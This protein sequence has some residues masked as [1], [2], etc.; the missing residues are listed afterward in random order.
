MISFAYLFFAYPV[1]VILF[2][3]SALFVVGSILTLSTRASLPAH[4]QI[5]EVQLIRPATVQ[6]A[7]NLGKCL[8][9]THE[10]IAGIPVAEK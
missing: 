1:A 7:F 3:R 5:Q 4:A 10:V 8:H 9:E 2:I 6:T